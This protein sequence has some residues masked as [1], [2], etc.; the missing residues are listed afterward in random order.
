MPPAPSPT[1]AQP[2]PREPPEYPSPAAQPPGG[3]PGR[4]GSRAR[5]RPTQPW[6]PHP[7]PRGLSSSAWL[8][9]LAATAG[10]RGPWWGSGSSLQPSSPETHKGWPRLERERPARLERPP[11]PPPLRPQGGGSRCKRV[12]QKHTPHPGRTQ[13]LSSPPGRWP[14]VCG[15]PCGRLSGPLPGRARG[16]QHLPGHRLH[17]PL[18]PGQRQTSAPGADVPRGGPPFPHP[19][20]SPA[21]SDRR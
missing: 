16:R 15:G 3:P 8:Q 6:Q 2:S 9:S 21:P 1:P 18:G 20:C 11:P 5:L 13:D 10:H 17:S 7:P 19:L 14:S 4:W 12:T